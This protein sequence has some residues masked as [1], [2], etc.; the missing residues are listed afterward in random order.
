MK[1][2]G[3][4]LPQVLEVLEGQS[5]YEIHLWWEIQSFV[6]SASASRE[7][8][9]RNEVREEEEGACAGESMSSAGS[10]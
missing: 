3:K 6:R 5:R 2:N 7:L 1:W 9:T 4:I 10:R 8:E